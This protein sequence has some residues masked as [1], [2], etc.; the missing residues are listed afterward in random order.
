MYNV[1]EERF[2]ELVR[3]AVESI[4]EELKAHMENVDIVVQDWPS[5]E[6][7]RR[8]GVPTGNIL[9]GLYE[10]IPRTARGVWYGQVVPDKITIFRLPLLQIAMDYDDLQE[11]V[12]HTVIHE[13]A[14][15]F[16]ISDNRLLELGAY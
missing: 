3:S 14:H 2:V 15:H 13:I 11:R 7:M 8:A 12:R 16:G 6:Q 5:G 1:D 9:L 10:G 4:P